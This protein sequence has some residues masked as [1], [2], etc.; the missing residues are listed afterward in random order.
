MRPS[1]ALSRTSRPSASPRPLP[2]GSSS[3]PHQ[4]TPLPLQTRGLQAVL[5]EVGEKFVFGVL[6][7]G[8]EL[9]QQPAPRLPHPEESGVQPVQEVHVLGDDQNV[10]W[11]PQEG[12]QLSGKRHR[13]LA[14]FEEVLQGLA[15]DAPAPAD[16]QARK[17]ALLAPLVDR[18]LLDPHQ[19]GDVLGPQK[20]RLPCS[21]SPFASVQAFP[22]SVFSHALVTLAAVLSLLHRP[23]FHDCTPLCL[24][25][26]D[27][28]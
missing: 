23:S 10:V 2:R 12:A 13:V 7:P 24:T 3:G 14:P 28:T 4:Q 16:L 17:L 18:G 1:S 5:R 21:R 25:S 19:L 27:F 6:L 20:L 26:L 22:A 11:L 15:P 8:V 9:H